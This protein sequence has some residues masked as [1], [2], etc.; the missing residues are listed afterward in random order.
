MDTSIIS[1]FVIRL[2]RTPISMESADFIRDQALAHLEEE[3]GDVFKWVLM[4]MVSVLNNEDFDILL[5]HQEDYP[6][7]RKLVTAIREELI[8]NGLKAT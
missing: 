5:L 2:C 4:L 1:N 3:Y 8:F 6:D 7:I